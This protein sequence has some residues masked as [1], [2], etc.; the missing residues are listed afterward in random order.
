M[1]RKPLIAGNWKMNLTL[2]EGIELVSTLGK[3]DVDFNK[4]DVLV[5]PTAPVLDAV[6]NKLKE[7]N[8]KIIVSGQNISSE[9]SGAYTGEISP[10]IIKSIGV[11]W[12]IIGHSER[13]SYYGDSD[14][15]I[16]KKLKN[17][18]KNGLSVIL[19]IGEL[20]EER[21]ANSHF[22]TVL[23]QLA[24]GLDGIKDLS[25]VVV[26]YEPV[27]AIGTGKTASAQD[28]Q[29]MH[30]QIRV[31]LEELYGADMASGVRILYGGSVK[32]DNISE[33]M[34]KDDIDG[35]LV[36]GASLKA[37]DFLQIINY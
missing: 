20:L 34:G 3:A 5:A 26:A 30:K 14:A 28:A 33:L 6:N 27:W 18:L 23:R 24:L 10:A 31:K 19:C 15:I 8:S 1:A 37:D 29:D 16:N 21:E 13:R 11:N 9:E 2:D 22:E 36:G 17:S 35:A 32:G 7:I 25:N 12:S 4:L